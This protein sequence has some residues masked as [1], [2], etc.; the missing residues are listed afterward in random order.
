ML[1]HL[2]KSNAFTI[3]QKYHRKLKTNKSFVFFLVE[4]TNGDHR[5]EGHG[6]EARVEVN[7]NKLEHLKKRTQIY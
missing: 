1:L 4:L 7:F 5:L 3:F 6:G 2:D